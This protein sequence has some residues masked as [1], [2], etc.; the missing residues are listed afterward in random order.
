MPIAFGKRQSFNRPVRLCKPGSYPSQLHQFADLQQL[1]LSYLAKRES[2]STIF[3]GGPRQFRNLSHRRP[4]PLS[5]AACRT[6]IAKSANPREDATESNSVGRD[7]S[8]ARGPSRCGR[9]WRSFPRCARSRR[10]PVLVP[11][12]NN[13]VLSGQ[14]DFPECESN[15]DQRCLLNGC[16]RRST[17]SLTTDNPKKACQPP[18]GWQDGLRSER[19]IGTR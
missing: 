5:R 13:L 17:S 4:T 11:P 7:C 2:L 18:D 19:C 9:R 12:K 8:A 3:T 14:P 1:P 15:C 10:T 6:A 16:S